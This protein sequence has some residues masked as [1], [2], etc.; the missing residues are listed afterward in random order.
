[1]RG[2]MKIKFL[3]AAGMVTGSCYWLQGDSGGLIVDMG[4]FQGLN[5]RELNAKWPEIDVSKI[6][7]VLLTHAHLDHGGRLPL[8]VKMGY[9]GKVYMTAPTRDL[10]E[11]SLRD[12]V[13][14]S[15]EDNKD[16][17]FGEEEVEQLLDQIE[18]LESKEEKNLGEFRIK[19]FGAGHI[20]GA[21]SVLV[22]TKDGSVVF[23]GDVGTGESPL[24]LPSETPDKA[25]VVVVES[26]YGDR[27]HED[28]DEKKALEEEIS[29]VSRDNGVLLLP[30]F[31]IQRS[32]RILHLLDHIQKEGG[33]PKNMK[34]YFDSPM[35]IEATEIFGKYKKY[36]SRELTSHAKTDDP[37]GFPGL[38]ITRRAWE[39][40]I[41]RKD[42]KAKII[43]A[44]SGMMSGGRIM[45]HAKEYL[46]NLNTR[47]LIV[48]YQA[49]GTLGR[50]IVGGEKVVNI[51][52]TEVEVNAK[53]RQIHSMSAHADQEQLLLWLSKIDE[54][55]R[56]ILSHGE[57]EARQVLG[58]K[59]KNR[60]EVP[61]TKPALGEV[62]EI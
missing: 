4:M 51:D 45:G 56:V 46:P 37:F 38:V 41:I 61:V 9:K 40:K 49:A 3:G 28:E 10:L 24:I 29:K 53:I 57:D 7:G 47:L 5:S 15:R 42:K 34:V 55:K 52:N 62:V 2:M 33:L 35:A 32:Q 43:V 6:D 8:L 13:K 60:F 23:S 36:F 1:M 44:G 21:V 31:S 39:K 16:K 59:I 11:L 12:T 20:L 48:G 30:V 58:E 22:E 27:L 25:D 18:I 26:T 17:L 50:Q 19:F 14:I 54:V